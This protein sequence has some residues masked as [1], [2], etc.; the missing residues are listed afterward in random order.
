MLMPSMG[1]CSTPLTWVGCSMPAASRIVG[2]RSMTWWNWVR[3]SPRAAIPRGHETAMPLR[4][5]P[6]CDAICFIHWNGASSAHAQA[7]L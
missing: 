4:V 3:N 7:A 5:P 6:K 2:A 1:F